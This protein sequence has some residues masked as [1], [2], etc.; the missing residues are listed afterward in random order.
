MFD[1][2]KWAE[3]FDTI[4]KNK[5]RTVLTGFSVFWGIFM[6]IILLGAGQGLSNGFSYNFRNTAKNTITLYGGETTKPWQGLAT[7]RPIQLDTWDVEALRTAIPG[8]EHITGNLRVWSGQ[9]QL[10]RGKN[11]GNFTISG[12]TPEF[13]A[14]Q[15]QQILEGRFINQADQIQTRKVIVLAEDSRDALFK[16]EDPIN[17]WVQVNNIPFQVV[18]VYRF[19]SSG[20]GMGQNSQVFIPL[21]V[22]Q[23]V[24][25]AQQTVDKITF[26]FAD[27]SLVGAK[28]AEQRA[29]AVLSMR[30]HFDP[31]DDRAVYV[32]NNVENAETFGKIFGGINAFLWIIGIGTIVA[33]IV[34]VSNIMLIVVKERT[35]EIGIRKALGATPAN[36][37][38]Q[39]IMEAVFVSAMAGY[40]GLVCGVGLLEWLAKMIPGTEM[41]RDPTVNINVALWATAV[42]IVAGALAGLIPARRAAA[43]RPIE[44]LRD[45]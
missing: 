11:Y 8:L 39:V 31:T 27:A 26:S 38:G 43:I 9:S 17:Q 35:K 6:L 28:Q 30:H 29:V 7:D 16:G 4:G 45:E 36:V 32:N 24:F 20:R 2:E 22:V 33:G 12:V 23:R 21:S 10:S 5:L 1:A 14:L 15:N 34:G 25:N 37:T 41:F 44:A 42:L 19:E 40:F 3:I 13:T 18:G